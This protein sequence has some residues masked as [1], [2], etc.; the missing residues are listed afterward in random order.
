M[1]GDSLVTEILIFRIKDAKIDNA[2]SENTIF[3]GGGGWFYEKNKDRLISFVS[4]TG[5]N[6]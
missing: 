1:V 2:E 5:N 3:A 6:I 4:E